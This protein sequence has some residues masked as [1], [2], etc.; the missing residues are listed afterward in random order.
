MQLQKVHRHD[1]IAR[2]DGV[3]GRNLA[4][5]DQLL[6]IGG[7]KK[8]T[9][10]RLIPIVANGRLGQPRGF[11]E[12]A[13]R[14]RDFVEAD[15]TFDHERVVVDVGHQMRA[16]VAVGAQQPAVLL[17]LRQDKLGGAG[18]R[19]AVA[20]FVEHRSAFGQAGDH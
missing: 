4:A 1:G 8:E 18:G 5:H 9:G 14:A 12:P 3:V 17:H 10:I 16:A 7:G 2:V 15:Q 20:G 13:Q 6:V 11:V 19:V